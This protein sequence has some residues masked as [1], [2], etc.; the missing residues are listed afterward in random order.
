MYFFYAKAADVERCYLTY[1]GSNVKLFIFYFGSVW[2]CITDTTQGW[3]HY[4]DI[5]LSN[6]I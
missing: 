6:E 5:N 4:F 1:S 2:G 3:N